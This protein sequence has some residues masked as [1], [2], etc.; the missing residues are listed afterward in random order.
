[1]S[2]C[3]PF[4]RI[5]PNGFFLVACTRLYNPLCPSV[6]RLVGR[7]HFT[8]FY[9]FISLTSLLLPKWSGD[10]KYGPCPPAR[11][12]GSCVSGLV[13][14]KAIWWWGSMC[15]LLFAEGH[16]S[17][18]SPQQK[19]NES[20]VQKKDNHCMMIVSAPVQLSLPSD[21]SVS[22]RTTSFLLSSLLVSLFLLFSSNP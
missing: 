6:G 13:Y 15:V 19:G 10:L 7:S 4:V 21:W 22:D 2:V 18:T 9:D 3:C 11:G 14:F 8:F 16:V 5:S 12:F 20:M 17:T 1:M